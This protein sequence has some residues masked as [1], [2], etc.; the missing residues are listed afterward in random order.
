MHGA[1]MK[2]MLI[3][4][5]KYLRAFPFIKLVFALVANKARKINK[6]LLNIR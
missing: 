3:D 1:T 4:V 2:F 5:K 6:D